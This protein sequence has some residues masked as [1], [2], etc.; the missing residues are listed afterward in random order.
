MAP[1]DNIISWS[2]WEEKY[3]PIPNPLADGFNG[4]LWD[5]M[6][7]TFGDDIEALKAMTSDNYKVWT[8]VDNN[9]NSFYLDIIPGTHWVNRMGYF[10]TEKGW[11][12]KNMVVSNDPSYKG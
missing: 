8:L 11:T 9:P 6:F 4:N 5:C 12:D 7:E 2:E 10:V 1:Q 3:T